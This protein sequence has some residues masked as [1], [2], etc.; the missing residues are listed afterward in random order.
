MDALLAPMIAETRAVYETPTYAQTVEDLF[1]DFIGLGRSED[2]ITDVSS[3]KHKYL[4]SPYESLHMQ[5][6]E[7]K[8]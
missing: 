3:D 5:P 8:G 1:G 2:G 7:P 6:E 4:A